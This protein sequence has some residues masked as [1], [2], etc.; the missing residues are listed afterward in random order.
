MYIC[1]YEC[2]YM[3]MCFIQV[4]VCFPLHNLPYTTVSYSPSPPCP[5]SHPLPPSSFFTPSPFLLL[6]PFPFTQVGCC[7]GYSASDY[8]DIHLPVPNTCRDQVSQRQST[9]VLVFISCTFFTFS[10]IY[11]S[12]F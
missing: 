3:Y 1:M 2:M 6:H 7:G 4:Y 10:F 8:T 11:R 5:L 9:P 12:F